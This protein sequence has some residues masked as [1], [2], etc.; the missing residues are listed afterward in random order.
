MSPPVSLRPGLISD[1]DAIVALDRVS[2][3]APHW[4]VAAYSAILDPPEISPHPRCLIVAELLPTSV[5]ALDRNPLVGF[6]V[7]LMHRTP[8]D[9]IA[10]LEYVIVAPDLRRA[11]I[12]RALC[13]NAIQWAR[14]QGAAGITLEVRAA[15][16][17]AISLYSELEFRQSGRRPNYYRDPDDD[18]I[19]MSLQL[20]VQSS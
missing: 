5:A 2:D 7:A 11:G 9:V 17:G 4:P 20:D 18:A 8:P 14:S 1:L 16:S 19:L 10:E 3:S 6:A 13:E 12:G 15:S